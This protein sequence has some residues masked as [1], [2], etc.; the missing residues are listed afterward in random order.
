MARSKVGSTGSGETIPAIPHMLFDPMTP[1]DLPINR[2]R[3]LVNRAGLPK[4]LA[5]A[6]Q[7]R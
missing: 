2:G 6:D 3:P 7:P 5:P 1:A 4:P